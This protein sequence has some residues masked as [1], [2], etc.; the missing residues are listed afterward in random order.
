MQQQ[1]LCLMWFI[2]NPRKSSNLL[3]K[4]GQCSVVQP[5][6]MFHTKQNPG[7]ELPG[8][9]AQLL[10]TTALVT[11]TFVSRCRLLQGPRHIKTPLNKQTK[12]KE[13]TRSDSITRQLNGSPPPFPKGALV[14]G[15]F[16]LSNAVCS[17]Y[18]ERKLVS[19]LAVVSD[20]S[21]LAL[22]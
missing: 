6:E 16:Y 7:Q 19:T 5:T 21:F 4:T 20:S 8:N 2:R 9:G 11:I 10:K 18:C 3:G 22:K 12:K 15:N 14:Y 1:R 17:C 13:R